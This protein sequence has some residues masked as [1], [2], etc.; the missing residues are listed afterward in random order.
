MNVTMFRQRSAL[1]VLPVLVG[2]LYLLIVSSVLAAET[3]IQN[4]ALPDSPPAT[5][6][7]P[8]NNIERIHVFGDVKVNLRMQRTQGIDQPSDYIRLSGA[9]P[10]LDEVEVE[11]ADGQL[12]VDARQLPVDANVV[13][14]VP[15]V[16]LREVMVDG[17]ST[18]RGRDLVSTDLVLEGHGAGSFL[19]ESIQVDDLT[20]IGHGQTHFSLSGQ[21]AHQSIELAGVGDYQA[22]YLHS[23]TSQ[24]SVTGDSAL[25]LWAEEILDLA[26]SGSANVRY[27]GAPW[28]HRKV[29][30]QA[31]VSQ[32]G[33]DASL[34]SSRPLRSGAK[35]GHTSL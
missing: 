4:P 32:M 5:R 24:V 27:A 34:S 6:T 29:S 3:E 2:T 7:L 1:L 25:T 18:V 16:Q 31:A 26:V 20:A 22:G 23:L 12:Y 19:M 17:D 33:P 8:A 28:V 15:V 14:D 21:V 30:G 9:L 35:V 11:L 10:V 13:L